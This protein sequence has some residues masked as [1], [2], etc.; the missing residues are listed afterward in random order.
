MIRIHEQK[1]YFDPAHPQS[2]RGYQHF[3]V[4]MFPSFPAG[5]PAAA[6]V[7]DYQIH[8][9]ACR[10]LVCDHF[11][12]PVRQERA[13]GPTG[14]FSLVRLQLDERGN[15][16]GFPH[17]EAAD[18]QRHAPPGAR[19]RIKSYIQILVGQGKRLHLPLLQRAYLLFQRAAQIKYRG[20]DREP[21]SGSGRSPGRPAGKVRQGHRP[22]GSFNQ[23]HPRF[24]GHRLDFPHPAG[25]RTPRCFESSE[26]GRHS[27]GLYA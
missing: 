8:S 26:R 3:C 4:R 16:Q 22:H 9:G 5:L 13:P 15:G 25:A 21:A 12:P 18:A 20:C 19:A 11:S 24:L 1:R 6:G 17:L 23:R 10:P 2:C 7:C 14:D 27:E